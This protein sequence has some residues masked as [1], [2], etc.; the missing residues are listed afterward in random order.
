[1]SSQLFT[2]LSVCEQEVIAGG[3]AQ[4]LN[5][6]LYF[7]DLIALGGTSFS[8]PNGSYSQNTA[9]R[10][11]RFTFGF[12]GATFGATEPVAPIVASLVSLFPTA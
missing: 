4:G 10:D 12:G 11:Q 1:M 7:S 2:E 3:L 5:G 6:S 9:V 8:G